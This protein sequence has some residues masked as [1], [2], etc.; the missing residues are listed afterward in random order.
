MLLSQVAGDESAERAIWSWTERH[1]LTSEGLLACHAR[2]DGT[3]LDAQSAAD[4][5]VLMAFALLRSAAV[6]DHTAQS[7]GR[8]IA[9]SILDREIVAS[10]GPVLV[11]GRWAATVR[12]VVVNPSYFMLSVFDELTDLTGDS[13]WSRASTRSVGL[14]DEATEGGCH[15]PSDWT[16]LIGGSLVSVGRPGTRLPA[17]YGADAVRLPI[18]FAASDRPRARAIAA[19]WWD[20]LSRDVKKPL[21]VGSD[22]PVT[23]IAAA[24]AAEAAG[25]WVVAAELRA[26]AFQEAFERPT[27]YGDA[28]IALGASLAGSRAIQPAETGTR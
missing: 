8:A 3:I 18:W 14:V 7:S 23:R 26:A 17:R 25:L 6:S 12:P 27:Y 10:R 28:W 1:L 2:I 11:A 22:N 4:A 16:H 9:R 19:R 20:A 24:A 21:E 13:R 15:L 5:D